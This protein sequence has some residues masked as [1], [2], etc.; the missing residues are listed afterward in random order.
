MEL[1]AQVRG[2]LDIPK[3]PFDQ[4]KVGLSWIMHE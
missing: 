1:E 2:A 3:D 4:L